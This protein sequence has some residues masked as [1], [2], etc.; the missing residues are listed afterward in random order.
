MV[1]TVATKIL[2]GLLLSE[3]AHGF[4]FLSGV[5]VN[6]PC[7]SR[8]RNGLHMVATSVEPSTSSVVLSEDNMPLD[9]SFL[10]PPESE[11]MLTFDP[12]STHIIPNCDIQLICIL[13]I[14]ALTL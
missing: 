12:V 10:A 14:S 7:V 13:S 2:L 5:R 4:N 9:A 11:A 3:G 6:K 8:S 1:G